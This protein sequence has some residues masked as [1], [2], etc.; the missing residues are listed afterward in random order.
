MRRPRVMKWSRT[1]LFDQ[2][3]DR[4]HLN[5]SIVGA[6]QDTLWPRDRY[7]GILQTEFVSTNERFT[8]EV[9]CFRHNVK[10]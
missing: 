5:E 7:F 4:H 2:S 3:V 6:R 1:A 10:T 9:I 8:C